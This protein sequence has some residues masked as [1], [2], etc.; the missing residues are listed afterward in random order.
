MDIAHFTQFKRGNLNH[1]VT[2]EVIEEENQFQKK[3]LWLLFK[4]FR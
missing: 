3:L 1:I 2:F 4:S